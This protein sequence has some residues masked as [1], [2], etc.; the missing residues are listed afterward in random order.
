MSKQKH[1]EYCCIACGAVFY[2]DKNKDTIKCKEC[3]STQ[4]I[5]TSTVAF[6]AS[7]VNFELVGKSKEIHYHK[8]HPALNP[9]VNIKCEGYGTIITT[10]TDVDCY[11]Y[12]MESGITSSQPF[13][14]FLRRCESCSSFD[15][16]DSKKYIKENMKMKEC[17]CGDCGLLFLGTENEE[18]KC[19]ECGSLNTVERKFKNI[20]RIKSLKLKLTKKG[21]KI[22]KDKEIIREQNHRKG[23][24]EHRPYRHFKGKL[25]YVHNVCTDHED[26]SE[27]LV[28]YQALYKPYN[29]YM[30]PLESF[31][32]EVD[33]NR[34]DNT[35]KQKYRFELYE[36]E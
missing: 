31:L 24:I 25:Y 7:V 4:V 1:E 16:C 36:G 22:H 8:T 33:I 14:S 35:T 3:R 27:R 11:F 29:T 30:R 26:A 21:K 28:I 20:S 19:K 32:E 34:E 6:N 23:V 13:E 2:D 17:Y 18:N 12:S 9:N 10:I 5:P 15:K